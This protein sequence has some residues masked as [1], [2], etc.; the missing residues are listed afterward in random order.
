VQQAP[1]VYTQ[2]TILQPYYAQPVYVPRYYPPVSLNLG[3]GYWGGGHHGHW[4]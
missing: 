4:R 3:F 1:V 2:Q